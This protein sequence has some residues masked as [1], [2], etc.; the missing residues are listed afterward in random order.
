MLRREKAGFISGQ[1]HLGS[2]LGE[3]PNPADTV[4][5][6]LVGGQP[7]AE[8]PGSPV[9]PKGKTGSL[10]HRNA[11]APGVASSA[12]ARACTEPREPCVPGL[13]AGKGGS[14]SHRVDPV[15]Q[16]NCGPSLDCPPSASPAISQMSL[17]GGVTWGIYQP[18][19][20]LV[21]CSENVDAVG[22]AWAGI[23]RVCK[24]PT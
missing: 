9:T 24:V 1:S 12:L 21:L 15:T 14:R 8:A 22:D 23:L 6:C 10:L 3:L 16:A 18:H 5:P 4:F 11:T 13:P 20:S 17:I 19:R 2:V 7:L